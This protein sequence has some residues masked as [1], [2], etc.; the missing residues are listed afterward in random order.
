[1]P[2][3]VLERMVATVSMCPW[4]MWPPMRV[5]GV[6]AR[7]RFRGVLGVREWRVVRRR[8]SGDMPTVKVVGVRWVIVRQV[9]IGGG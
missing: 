3:G 6:R 1:M 5:E 2:S 9:P 8:V 7:S 4:T